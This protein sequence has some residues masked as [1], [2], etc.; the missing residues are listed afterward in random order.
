MHSVRISKIEISL[1]VR[2]ELIMKLYSC[3][4]KI[5]ISLMNIKNSLF[6]KILSVFRAER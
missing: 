4:F 1:R 6:R 5:N 2:N 3:S